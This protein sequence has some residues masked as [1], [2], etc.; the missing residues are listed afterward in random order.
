M[1][2]LR[3][4]VIFG[5][6]SGEHEIS[7]RSA[8]SIMS[9]MD[10]TRYDVV[11]IGIDRGGRWYLYDDALRMLGDTVARQGELSA[12]EARVSLLPQPGHH[13]LV[14]LAGGQAAPRG[15]LDVV[16]P[17]LH[18]T[19]GEDGT[20]QGLLE[21]AGFPTSAP[22]CSARQSGWIRMFRSACCATRKCRFCPM[23]R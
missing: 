2:K 23:A 13:P 7:L 8:L 12:V 1:S 19:Y 21:L 11:P 18:G 5:G 17:V 3:V 16:F 14:S 20:V 10:R 6:R 9:A 22:V 15:A 4:G